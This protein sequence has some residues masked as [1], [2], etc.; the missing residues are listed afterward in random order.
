M[1][2]RFVRARR[3][4]KEGS[5]LNMGDGVADIMIRRGFAVEEREVETAMR[6]P[7]ESAVRKRG[8]ARKLRPSECRR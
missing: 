1:R 7:Q 8:N 2:V 6:A 5:V 3:G 4:I